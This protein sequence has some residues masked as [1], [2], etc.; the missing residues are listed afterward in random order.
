MKSRRYIVVY[1][2]KV[3]NDDIVYVYIF[4]EQIDELNKVFS[5]IDSIYVGC[6]EYS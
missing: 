2:M 5:F 6:G 4:V 3:R 1:K